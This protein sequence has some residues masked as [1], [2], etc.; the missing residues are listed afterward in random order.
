MNLV[1]LTIKRLD[2][3]RVSF[4]VFELCFSSYEVLLRLYGSLSLIIPHVY[5]SLSHSI[6]LVIGLNFPNKLRLSL[7]N[8]LRQ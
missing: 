5:W 2:Q 7:F 1:C 8:I 6:H 4:R 3:F